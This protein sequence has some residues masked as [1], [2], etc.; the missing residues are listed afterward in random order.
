MESTDQGMEVAPEHNLL[1]G[2]GQS[3]LE[4]SGP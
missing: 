3:C 4:G 1:V 2:T